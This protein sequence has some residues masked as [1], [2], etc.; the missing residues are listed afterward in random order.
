MYLLASLK[1]GA[2]ASGEVVGT[3]LV[4]AGLGWVYS[5]AL[6]TE[7]KNA[8]VMSMADGMHRL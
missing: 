8:V 1:M 6:S 7:D 5:G 4:V 3:R 2:G